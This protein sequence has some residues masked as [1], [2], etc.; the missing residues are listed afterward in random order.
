MSRRP[1]SSRVLLAA[2][3]LALVPVATGVR[4]QDAGNGG[5]DLRG[6]D[7]VGGFP[8]SPTTAPVASPE[9]NTPPS[10]DASPAAADEEIPV[11]TPTN[12]TPPDDGS[13]NYGKARKRKP[14]L[15]KPNP[16]TSMPLSPLVPYR[17]APGQKRVLNPTAAPKDAIDPS[18]PAP[19]VAVIPSPLRAKRPP[20]ELDPYAPTGVQVGELVLKPFVETSTRL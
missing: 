17:G 10:I 15:Y 2:A 1:L 13:P 3:T 7:G 18:G 9:Q 14:K 16:K 5:V 19:T 6:T 8:T 20:V 11:T 12:Q 4:G